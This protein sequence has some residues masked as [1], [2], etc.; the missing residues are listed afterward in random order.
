MGPTFLKKKFL[1]GVYT[2]QKSFWS[3]FS[4]FGKYSHSQ[5]GGWYQQLV[6][7][8]SKKG[9]FDGCWKNENFDCGTK[10]SFLVI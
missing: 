9:N 3:K 8:L 1:M 5:M 10:F 7:P 2:I 4:F 6:G